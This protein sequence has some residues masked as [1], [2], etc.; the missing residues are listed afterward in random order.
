V[1]GHSAHGHRALPIPCGECDLQF[2][3]GDLRI[4]EKELVEV[5]HAE[6]QQGIG[7]LA[8]GGRVLAHEGRGGCVGRWELEEE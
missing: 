6:K 2:P 5:A 1:V 8:L 3:G 4:F 7:I